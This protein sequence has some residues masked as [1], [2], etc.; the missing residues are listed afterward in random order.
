MKK[1]DENAEDYHEKKHK[2]QEKLDYINVSGKH[3]IF[4]SFEC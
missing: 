3:Y 2:I 4:L 1:L